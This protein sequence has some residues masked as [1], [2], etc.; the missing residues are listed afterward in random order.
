[1]KS[2]PPFR[3][4]RHALVLALS[5][6]SFAHAQNTI[7]WTFTPGFSGDFATGSNWAG[8]VAPA[9]DLT[10]DIATFNTAAFPTF[11]ANRSVAGI[12]VTA[13]GIGLN[14]SG[15]LTLGA[16]GLISTTTSVST[17]SVPLALGA[18]TTFS[19][20]NV[21]TVSSTVNLA[22]FGLTLTGTGT[23]STSN[24][25]SGVISGTGSITK[26]G[27]NRWVLSNAS[28]SF[29]GPVSV[30]SGMLQVTANNAIPTA[31][32]VTIHANT[33][34]N[35]S[36]LAVANN[37][38][39]TVNSLSF[40]ASAASAGAMSVSLGTSST[41]TLGGNVTYSGTNN[42]GAAT[43]SG[44]GGT[45][46]LGGNRTFDVSNSTT[47]VTDLSVS[48]IVAGTGHS[49][50]K[51][52]AGFMSLS[53]NN[54][55]TGGTIVSAG[56]LIVNNTTGSG[57]GTG[58][59][60]VQ[61][62]ASLGGLGSIG[63]T[64]TIESGGILTPGGA[65]TTVGNLT[66]TNG[67]TLNDGA[68]FNFELGATSDKIF[69]SGG[70]LTGSTS[71]GGLTLNLSNTGSFAAGTYT[72]ID[73]SNGGTTLSSFDVTDFNMGTT[74]SGYGYSLEI[75]SSMLQLTASA[76]PEPSTYAL[77]GG[78]AALGLAWL[79]RRRAALRISAGTT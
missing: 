9:N 8:G 53:G 34:G 57:V 36:T 46:N 65:V 17:S 28:N 37:I 25:I 29:S 32:A 10:S 19:N 40:G 78:S 71:A 61:S 56:S 69:V 48:A 59:V 72:L 55:Y 45:L 22:G 60:T 30:N 64:T 44:S 4:R 20:P 75:N 6:A 3:L 31:N 73:F 58:A 54:T 70:T 43:I 5:L 50:T 23:T 27:A 74:I 2:L 67:L 1:M 79:R 51:T 38:S 42:P 15:T 13:G 66:F 49:L 7:T 24:V 52:G 39:Q 21:F 14:G 26:E 16:S 11:S 76:I 33:A 12:A 63:G 68:V 41:L 62:G 35:T 18:N 47:V 77:L